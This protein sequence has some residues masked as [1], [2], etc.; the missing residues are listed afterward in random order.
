MS[1]F[2]DWK[3]PTFDER[4]MTRWNWMCTHPE[5]LEIGMNVDIGA[6]T[7]IQAEEGV[8][9]ED[10]VQISGGCKIYS[11]STILGAEGLGIVGES[12]V[13]YRRLR[14]K[15][16]LKR[17]ACVGANSVVLPGVT[18][19]EEAVVGALSLVKRDVPAGEIWGGVPARKIVYEIKLMPNDGSFEYE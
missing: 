16:V 10:D 2:K 4:G 8:I 13:V 7:Y 11:V 19:G 6:F 3:P 18:I 12:D 17:A 5:N 14:G 9:L 1:R 15:I